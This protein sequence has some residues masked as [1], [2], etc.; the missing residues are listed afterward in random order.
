VVQKRAIELCH[1]T[2]VP[3]ITAT[4]MLDSMM[5]NPMPTRAEAS[6]VANAVFDGSDAVMLSVETAFGAHPVK[7]AATMAAII[8]EAEQTD[9][10]R[11]GEPVMTGE[12]Y[13]SARCICRAAF[14]TAEGVD[15]RVIVALTTSG[16]TARLMSKFRPRAPI[17][18]FTPSEATVRRLALCWGT[19]PMRMDFQKGVEQAIDEVAA[20]L[21]AAGWIARGDKIVVLAGSHLEEGGTNLLRLYTH[22]G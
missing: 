4:Q 12:R 2:G 16:L 13:I 11:L 1:N 10:F 18:A 6:D 3:V 15:A 7:A 8:R 20:R 21:A 22:G 9:Y 17:V 5:A 19:V 14:H